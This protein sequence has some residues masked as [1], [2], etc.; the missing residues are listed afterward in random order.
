LGASGARLATAAVN[1]LEV[2]SGRYALCTMCIGVGQGLAM[3]LENCIGFVEDVLEEDAEHEL[4]PDEEDLLQIPAA[5]RR[6]ALVSEARTVKAE[7]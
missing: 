4:E 1:Q 3:I 2:I 6:G 7:K 5:E